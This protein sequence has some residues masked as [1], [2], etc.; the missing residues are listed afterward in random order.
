M[1]M[2][3]SSIHALLTKDDRAFLL[4][5]KNAEPY[6]SLVPLDALQTM[7]AVQWKLA[8]IRKLKLN[9]KKHAKQLEALRK[10]LSA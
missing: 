5:F 7:P 6:W 1:E 3:C 10:V 9:A 4:S 8:N 2:A